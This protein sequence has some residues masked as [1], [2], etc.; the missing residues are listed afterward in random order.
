MKIRSFACAALALTL[1][2]LGR[3]APVTAADDILSINDQEYL[4]MAGL[5]VML[6]HD[7]YPEGHQGGVGVIENGQRVGTN[8]DIR[9]EPTP[10]QWQPTPQVGERKVDRQTQEISVRMTYP[11]ESQNRKGLNPIAYPDLKLSYVIKVKPAGSAFRII[12]DFDEPIPAAWVGKIGFNFELFP[13]IL[14]GK[15][16]QIGGQVGVFPRQANGPGAWIDGDYELDPLGHGPKLTVAPESD[17][18]RMTIEAVRGGEIQLLDG[19][20]QH[21]NGWFVVRSLVPAGATKGAIEWLVTPHINPGWKSDPV[22]QVSQVGY[23]PKQQKVATIE[24]DRRETDIKPVA[25]YRVTE[26]GLEKVA[27]ASPKEWGR[28]LRFHYVQFDFSSVTTPGIYEVGYGDRRSSPFQVSE[29][30]YERNVWQPTVEYFLPVQMAHMR[31]NDKYRVWH[32]L[33][34]I[35]D[36]LMAPVN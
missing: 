20:A 35:D 23:H 2:A 11:N 17:Q 25:L 28:F 27:E 34:H 12:V 21:N 13:G 6:A 9:L 16:F 18:Q 26:A 36:A 5:N 24:L 3:A 31:V 15:S 8:G 1:A 22:I 10:G 33:S 7:F 14:F 32:G 4:E 19:R 29:H 30:V